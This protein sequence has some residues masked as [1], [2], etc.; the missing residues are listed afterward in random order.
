MAYR[1]G[2]FDVLIVGCGFCGSVIARRQ[3]ERGRKTLILER[4]KRI[5]G[6]MFDE[7]DDNGILVHRYGPHTFHTDDADVYAFIAQYGEWDDYVLKCAADLDGVMSPV[8]FNF[9]TIDLLYERPGATELKRRLRKRYTDRETVTIVELLECEDVLIKKYAERLFELD[10]RPYTAKQWGIE[11]KDISPEV[12]RRVPV[13]LSY[14]NA[15]FNDEYQCMP[16]YGYARFFENL[17]NHENIRVELNADALDVLK[18]DIDDG[19]IFFDGKRLDVPVVYTGALD[20]L[21]EYRYGRLPYRSLRF[22]YQTKNV[23][24]FQDAAVTAYPKAE[25]YTRITEYKKLPPQDVP[26]VTTVVYE[27]PAPSNAGTGGEPY[28]PILTEE[29]I[30]VY[31]K[32]RRDAKRIPNLFACGRLADYKYYNMDA[33]VKRAFEADRRSLSKYFATGVV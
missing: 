2:A 5:A 24:S 13:R 16:K 10:Y 32:Y 3:A 33:A 25:G 8:P 26:G 22:D 18:A 9:D 12:L 7:Y 23:D 17:L 30:G 29:N 31:E 19:R 21:L 28:Y 1:A 11:P 27:Y 6:N 14:V 4:R 20:E 15:Y